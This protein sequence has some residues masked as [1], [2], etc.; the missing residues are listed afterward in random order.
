[1]FEPRRMYELTTC[2]LPRFQPTAHA[3]IL[4]FGDCVLDAA[5]AARDLRYDDILVNVIPVEDMDDSA[6]CSGL[7]TVFVDSFPRLRPRATVNW[8]WVTPPFIACPSAAD[9]EWEW[10]PDKEDIKKAVMAALGKPYPVSNIITGN[11]IEDIPIR[12]PF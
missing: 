11:V 6:L 4:T 1:M 8:S 3:E 9:L 5:A 10:Y 12:G 2:G 7:P